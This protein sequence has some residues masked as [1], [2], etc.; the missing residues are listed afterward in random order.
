MNKIELEP[1]FRDMY[2]WGNVYFHKTSGRQ[3]IQLYNSSTDYTGMLYSRYLMCVKLGYILPSDIHVDHIDNDKTND[4][5]DNLQLL[6][7]SDNVKKANEARR[8]NTLINGH[9][10]MNCYSNQKCR[11]DLCKKANSDYWEEYKKSRQVIAENNPDDPEFAHGTRRRY[12]IGCRCTLC[13][14]SNRTYNKE[15]KESLKSI[16]ETDTNDPRLKHGTY[17]CYHVYKCRCFSCTQAYRIYQKDY[18]YRCMY[19]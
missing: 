15:Y 11:C 14:Q 9:G 2:R 13:I 5:L 3:C 17:T 6:T 18:R 16:I 4:S 19:I 12:S 7:S 1:P 10:T 8:Q